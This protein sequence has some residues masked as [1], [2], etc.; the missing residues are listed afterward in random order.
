MP[1]MLGIQLD[2]V[3]T[4]CASLSSPGELHIADESVTQTTLSLISSILIGIVAKYYHSVEIFVKAIPHNAPAMGICTFI[5]AFK[6][7]YNY[8]SEARPP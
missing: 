5:M 2:W 1:G 8:S 3:D 7:V 6:I 4:P